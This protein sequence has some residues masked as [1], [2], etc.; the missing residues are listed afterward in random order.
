MDERVASLRLQVEEWVLTDVC[1]WAS[2]SGSEHPPFLESLGRVL[3]VVLH[4]PVL[5]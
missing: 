4:H 3:E 1:V 2:N 5:G